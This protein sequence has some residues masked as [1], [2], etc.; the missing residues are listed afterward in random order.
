MKKTPA[1]IIVA[2]IAAVAGWLWW[3]QA[4]NPALAPAETSG[5][6]LQGTLVVPPGFSPSDFTIVSHGKSSQLNAD[7]TFTAAAYDEGV[8]V[9]AAMLRDKEFGFVKI[10]VTDEGAS[11]PEPITID[12]QTTA[13]GL[14]FATPQLMTS[15]PQQA[16]ET[17]AVI[18]QDPKVA[19]FAD[20]ISQVLQTDD[21]LA[22][23]EYRQALQAALTSVIA[24]LNP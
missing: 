9:I 15:D 7:G 14:V 2:V 3:R 19:A 18:T 22:Q 16:K 21:P 5:H 24:T 10:V 8:T 4:S 12:T 6:K 1:I 13:V 20:A 11:M 17:L 23:P